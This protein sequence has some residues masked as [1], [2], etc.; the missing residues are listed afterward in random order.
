MSVLAPIQAGVAPADLSALLVET[1]QLVADPLAKRDLSLIVPRDRLVEVVRFLRDDP[2]LAFAQLVDVSGVD[3]L[4][5][6]EHRGPRFAVLYLFKS[7]VFA[8]RLRLKVEVDEDDAVVP[9]LHKLYKSAN[10][11]ERETWD[12]YGVVFSGHPN[13]KR[14]LN[15]H[16]FTGHPLRKDYPCQKRQK[17][18]ANDPM[19]DQ[20]TARLEGKGWSVQVGGTVTV[21]EPLTYRD[22]K[23]A[24]S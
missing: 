8:H 11:A 21:G 20:L 15:H 14:L 23:G 6:P 24:A 16:E 13:L 10:W 7:V 12:Q 1:F 9:S 4:A 19:L 5:Y 22:G 2:R 18:S 17:L 3:Y